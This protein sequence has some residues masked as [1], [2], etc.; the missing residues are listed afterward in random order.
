MQITLKNIAVTILLAFPMSTGTYAQDGFP[1]ITHFDYSTRMAG[2]CRHFTQDRQGL[3]Y[4]SNRNGL[5]SFDGNSWAHLAT[6]GPLHYVGFHEEIYLAGD[7]F[8]SYYKENLQGNLTLVKIDGTDNDLFYKIHQT[9]SG[10]VYAIGLN[11]IYR[12][13]R[14]EPRKATIFYAEPD[15]GKIFTDVF[16][17]GEVL[18]GI[19]NSNELYRLARNEAL[20]IN[21]PLK[22]GELFTFSFPHNGKQL[23]ATNQGKLY[24]FNGGGF[25]PLILNDRQ[26]IEESRLTG[27]VSVDRNTIALSTKFGGV[28]IVDA[29]SGATKLILDASNGLP[30]DD[31]SMLGVDS[32]KGIWIFH[33]LG[34]TRVDINLT[35]HAFSHYPGLSGS[36][37][38]V[39]HFNYLYAGT[40]NGLY[41]LQ[42]NRVT[43][44]ISVEREIV[45]TDV[46]PTISGQ[47]PSAEGQTVYSKKRR[48]LIDRILGRSNDDF[49]EA[50]PEVKQ[51]RPALAKAKEVKR[52]TRQVSLGYAYERVAGITGKVYQLRVF[53]QNLM[54]GTSQGLF[55]L[56]G[57]ELTRVIPGKAISNMV[58]SGDSVL[59]VSSDAD[60]YKVKQ[61]G[62]AFKAYHI[63][64]INHQSIGSIAPSKQSLLVGS[65]DRIYRIDLANPKGSLTE[66]KSKGNAVFLPM[67]GSN[68]E[69]CY[70]VTPTH[71]FEYLPHEDSLNLIAAVSSSNDFRLFY[72]G[73][74][75]YLLKESLTWKSLFETN[76]LNKLAGPLGLLDK[77]S[78]AN[79]TKENELWA[80]SGLRYIYRLKPISDQVDY[81]LN[82]KIK[83]VTDKDANE[84]NTRLLTLSERSSRFSVEIQAPF[85]TK[86]NGIEY[87]YRIPGLMDQ[88]SEWSR[89]PVLEFSYLKAGDHTLQIRARD[90][91]GNASNEVTLNV[92]VKLPF[93]KTIWFYAL[94]AALLVL[95]IWSYIKHREQKLIRE[96]RELEQKVRERTKTIQEQK[97]EIEAQ[98]DE[99]QLRNEEILQ[100]KEEIEAQRDEIMLQRDKIISQNQEI[101][102]SISY[103]LRIQKAVMPSA[104]KINAILSDYFILL[105]PRDIVSGDFYWFTEKNGNIIIAIA[106]CTGHGVPG[107]FMSLLGITLLDEVV[108]HVES[109]RPDKILNNLRISVKRALS[110]VGKE[111]EAKDGMD[112]ALVV[113]EKSSNRLF[114]SGAYNPIYIVRNN[115]LTEFKGDKMPVG[116]HISELDSFT[117]HTFQLEAGDCLYM[118]SDG[119]ADQ[120]GGEGNRKFLAKNFKELLIRVSGLPMPAQRQELENTLDQWM[121]GT[122]DQVDD[123]LVFGMRV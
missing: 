112:I 51:S 69:Q 90:A 47:S 123:I 46:S 7:G 17:V 93:Y 57:G 20:L 103:A 29:N 71:L 13:N 32:Q 68:G 70:V 43:K 15:S 72:A 21:S 39:C 25:I 95:G 67:L 45:A 119:Y 122:H 108:S 76:N 97:E 60:V 105:R 121:G 23:L 54:V 33:S 58:V 106:D 49:K 113:I 9:G 99:L 87:Q 6:S 28:I 65:D 24:W 96:N 62:G 88:W 26:Y 50:E 115:Q 101:I 110:Q 2:G 82:I 83:R 5:F 86:S 92:Y 1:F 48:N 102:K 4:V 38:S 30:D 98:R 100:Q 64:Q 41:R 14:A 55:A 120:F 36:V 11:G 74:K 114:F 78:Y 111:H 80:V 12:I 84:L 59:Y 35:V 8:I 104:E 77:V 53:N 117:L 107:A 56:S 34:I 40:S 42:E 109:I 116:I 37:L 3:V 91:L 118:F 18:Y 44:T 73:G 16:S 61:V 75:S 19:K 81:R 10:G 94:V 52:I 85:Y 79:H 27:G 31:V 22:N 89:N 66:I 63:A